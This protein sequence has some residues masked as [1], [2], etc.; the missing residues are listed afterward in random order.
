MTTVGDKHKI[1]RTKYIIEKQTGATIYKHYGDV[2]G[3]NFK[4]RRNSN[5]TIYILDYCFIYAKVLIFNYSSKAFHNYFLK[6]SCL[7]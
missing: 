2:E 4:I 3:F 5:C 7:R 6:K 1:D